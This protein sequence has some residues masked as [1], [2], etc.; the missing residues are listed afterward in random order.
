MVRVPKSG[1]ESDGDLQSG[2]KDKC[3]VIYQ[4][5][6]NVVMCEIGAYLRDGM[7]P[8]AVSLKHKPVEYQARSWDCFHCGS[9]NCGHT[10]GQDSIH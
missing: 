8:V 7:A 6:G 10:P 3:V 1:P 2:G 9:L 4:S 5:P